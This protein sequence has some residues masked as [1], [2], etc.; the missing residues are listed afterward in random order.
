MHTWHWHY[1]QDLPFLQCSLLDSWP[2][3]FLTRHFSP[4]LPAELVEVLQPAATAY[5][6]KQVHGNRVLTT[7]T[8]DASTQTELQEADGLLTENPAEAVWVA[9]ADCVP[10][11][12]ADTQSRNVAAVH[13]GWRGTAAKIVPEAIAKFQAKGSQL[14][15]LR[16]VM[17]PAISG[18]V[19]Q[20]ST[21]VALQLSQSF[22]ST[23]DLTELI[24]QPNSPFL[25][26]SEPDKVR[27]DVRLVNKLQLEQLGLTPE[28]F[29]ISP[30]CTYQTPDLF[31]SYR[32]DNQKKVQWSGI[33][34]I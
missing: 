11:L 23:E 10:V 21:D 13:A 32:R 15:N 14:A 29:A 22:N 5:R 12:I 33:V 8:I 7:T 18:P 25:I 2:H 6:V 4:R 26:D 34:S 3:G 28:Q 9:S 19:Y 31:F 24:Q 27:V 20:V 30:D 17:G 16:V 1:W